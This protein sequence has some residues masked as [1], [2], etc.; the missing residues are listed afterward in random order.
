VASLGAHEVVDYRS[1]DFTRS[2]GRYDLVLDLVARRSV[3]AYRR[4]LSRGGRYFC[5]GGSV[6]TLLGVLT[7]GSIIG[8]LTRR[9]LRV[10]SVKQGPAHFGPLTDLCVAG[11]IVIN[12]D[13]TFELDAVPEALAYV[14]QGRSRGKVVVECDHP[15]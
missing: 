3:F 12:I 11:D 7:I 15:H 5:V 4:A 6:P 8:L 13:R 2:G 1:Q 14:G 9:R 10:L